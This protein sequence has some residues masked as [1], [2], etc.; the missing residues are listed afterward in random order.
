VA[1]FT[2]PQSWSK[3]KRAAAIGTLHRSKPDRDNI[4]KGILDAMFEEDAG[5]A[6]GTIEKRWAE[7]S[8][9]EIT[10][11]VDEQCGV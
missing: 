8:R 5:I 11:D 6:S 2:P 10:I 7:N 3:K 1:Y 9:I 4:D